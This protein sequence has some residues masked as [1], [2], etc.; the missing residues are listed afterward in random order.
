MPEL[1][2]GLE[3]YFAKRLTLNCERE[4]IANLL[5]VGVIAPGVAEEA[6]LSVEQRMDALQHSP[7]YRRLPTVEE[8]LQEIPLFALCS[9]EERTVLARAFSEQVILK[10]AFLF[11]EGDLS[12][13]LYI[14]V[15]GALGIYKNET[16][17][18]VLGGGDIVGEMALL[19]HQPRMACALA[20]T[21]VTVLE[22]NAQDFEQVTAQSPPLL[23]QTWLSFGRHVLD[24]NFDAYGPLKA[25]DHHQRR[26]LLGQTV[27]AHLLAGEH[28]TV[29]ADVGAA[30]LI[31]GTVSV[32]GERYSGQTFMALNTGDDIVAEKEARL[33]WLV[34]SANVDRA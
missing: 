20:K 23:E 7:K 33:L 5:Q 2:Q 34:T 18:T 25:L 1:T 13:S 8:L 32:V 31:V 27:Q 17:L 10:G 9:P 3:T 24:N 14:I 29:P 26:Q 30:F 4:G 15:R 12:D 19:T 11:K 6:L 28:I 16:Q 22:I 21:T